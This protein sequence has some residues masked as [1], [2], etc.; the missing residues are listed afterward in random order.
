MAVGGR[1]EVPGYPRDQTGHILQSPK[2]ARSV[3]TVAYRGAPE[4]DGAELYRSRTRDKAKF[5][6]CWLVGFG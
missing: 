2:L 5:L 1:P 3:G 4:E 6:V